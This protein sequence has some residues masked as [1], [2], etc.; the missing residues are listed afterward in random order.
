LRA[1][2]RYF[3]YTQLFSLSFDIHEEMKIILEIF[4][5]LILCISVQDTGFLFNS[6]NY[7][8]GFIFAADEESKMSLRNG[9]K[10]SELSFEV[11]E[12]IPGLSIKAR[13]YMVENKD[14]LTEREAINGTRSAL[15][16]VPGIGEKNIKKFQDFFILSTVPVEGIENLTDHKKPKKKS[17]KQKNNSRLKTRR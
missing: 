1:D 9:V 15:L 11:L 14:R 6:Y 8:R 13:Q 5:V 3:P 4:L 12:Y 16:T 7:L 10:I 17:T 2:Q